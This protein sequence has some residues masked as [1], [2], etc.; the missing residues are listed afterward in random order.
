MFIFQPYITLKGMDPKGW[1]CFIS[2]FLVMMGAVG[3]VICQPLL[4][5]NRYFAM[6]HPEKSKKFFKKP[7]CICMH[8]LNDFFQQWILK[9]QSYVTDYKSGC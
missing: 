4:S 1:W 7:Y 5:I 8:Q 2:G 9:S 6:F 3:G